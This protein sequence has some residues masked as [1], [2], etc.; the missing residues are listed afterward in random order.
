M[1]PNGHCASVKP[2][3]LHHP[4]IRPVKETSPPERRLGKWHPGE[5]ISWKN[6]PLYHAKHEILEVIF[7]AWTWWKYASS[8]PFLHVLTTLK[9]FFWSNKNHQLNDWPKSIHGNVY[10]AQ[11][12]CCKAQVAAGPLS[13]HC[14]RSNECS[15]DDPAENIAWSGCICEMESCES[16]HQSIMN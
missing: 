12:T 13:S 4:P 16:N 9:V 8:H 10:A 5:E 15:N 6:D 7:G 14:R 1:L 11:L 3:I 2:R